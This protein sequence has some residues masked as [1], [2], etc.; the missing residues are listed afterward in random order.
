[1][2]KNKKGLHSVYIIVSIIAMA[3][4]VIAYCIL[5][6]EACNSRNRSEEVVA[7]INR[8]SDIEYRQ[9]KVKAIEDERNKQQ[10]IKNKAEVYRQSE[11]A[12]MEQQYD[13][14][15]SITNK[16]KAYMGG[17]Y[18]NISVDYLDLSTGEEFK[19]NSNEI[20]H[21]AS[22]IKVPVVM[23]VL[24]M[25]NSG[26]IKETDTMEYDEASDYEDG[27]GELQYIDKSSP[28]SIMQL[29]EYA[30]KYSDNIAVNM[31][32]RRIGYDNIVPILKTRVG[33]DWGDKPNQASTNGMTQILKRIYNEGNP[34]YAK[35]I[36]WLKNTIFH[37]RLD[38]YINECSVAHKIGDYGAYTHDVGIVYSD[39]PYI[40]SVYTHGLSNSYE[41]IAQIS[42]IVY[43]ERQR[44]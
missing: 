6:T 27:A 43:D 31:L 41:Q 37:D 42:K 9:N 19:I 13:K 3:S 34:Y 1:M 2:N 21:T 28:I 7:E 15:T 14:M 16:I 29:C 22:T 26:E 38:K 36:E 32:V 40:L 24:D 17:E 5:S 10:E 11:E 23:I 39:K 20:E 8:N 25:I 12:V 18:T 33:V 44:E 30:I 35:E 4:I